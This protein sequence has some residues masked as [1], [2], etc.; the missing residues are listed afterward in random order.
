MMFL[1][2]PS[3]PEVKE[4][5]REPRPLQEEEPAIPDAL[6]KQLEAVRAPVCYA[7]QALKVTSASY[8]VPGLQR[9]WEDLVFA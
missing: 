7:L 2:W 1:C 8:V 5:P 4:E 6:V 9:I 3:S